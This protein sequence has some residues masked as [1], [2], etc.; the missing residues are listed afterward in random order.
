MRVIEIYSSEGRKA[1]SVEL[2]ANDA[3]LDISA[4]PHGTYYIRIETDHG[5]TVKQLV[6]L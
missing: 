1:M 2:D 3:I 6:V 4:L 5:P